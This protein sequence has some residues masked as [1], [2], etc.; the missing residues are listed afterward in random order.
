M[1]TLKYIIPAALLSLMVTACGNN[2]TP[3]HT[4]TDGSV[5][6]KNQDSLNLT[7]FER[8]KILYRRCRACHTLGQDEKHKVGPNLYNIFGSVAGSREEFNYSK[9]MRASE[10]IWTDDTMNAYLQRPRDYIPGNRM[11]FIG[12]KHEKDRKAIIAYMKEAKQ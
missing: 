3:V 11:S 8:G 2:E 4:T 6:N 7:D 9:A 10:I 5:T 1:A 12:L